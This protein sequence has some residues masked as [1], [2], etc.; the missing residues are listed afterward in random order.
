MLPAKR[1]STWDALEACTLQL[2][3][4]REYRNSSFLI[5]K[6][7]LQRLG[8]LRRIVPHSVFDLQEGSYGNSLEI[9]P[10]WKAD[11]RVKTGFSLSLSL[12]LY[13]SLSFFQ[14]IEEEVI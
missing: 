11:G 8:A 5:Q 3:R 7:V 10:G 1:A 12:C 6:W 9:H 13:L 2:I 14:K 4:V